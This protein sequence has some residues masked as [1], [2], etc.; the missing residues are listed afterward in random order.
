MKLKSISIILGITSICSYQNLVNAQTFKKASKGLE[1]VIIKDVPG[2]KLIKD[3]S[4]VALHIQTKMADSV[5]FD[6][7]KINNNEPIEQQLTQEFLGGF[8][9]GFTKLSEGDSAILRM[10]VDSAFPGNQK[11]PFAK[12]GDLVSYFIKVV[13]VKTKEEYENGKKEEASI[14]KAV[15]DKALLAYIKQNKLKALKTNSGLYYVIDKAGN[16]THPVATDKVKVHYKGT[17]LD[18]T[19]F[20]SSFDRNEP[21]EFALNGVIK[22]WTEGIPYF[23]EGGKGKLLI[24]SAL[25]Y[26]TNPPPGSSIK[27]N[28]P[29]IFDV[30]LLEIVKELSEA[31][32]M[33]KDQKLIEE[34]IKKNNLKTEKTASGLHFVMEKKGNGKHAKASDEVKVHYKGTLLDGT[35]F[36]S[37]Y[38]RGEPITFPL[39]N[40][41][42][43]WTEGIP[44]L[45]EGGKG[46]LIIPSSLA[47]GKNAPP[48]TPIKANDVLVFDVELL[49]VIAK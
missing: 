28:S 1:Y 22:G 5:M 31:D 39:G 4:Y 15:D 19:K 18:G 24:P 43:G 23:E 29:L 7:Y 37:S 30:E 11:P 14:Q 8:M 38:D 26:G 3:G 6:S 12:P 33:A 32:I 40:V 9:E 10:P 46:K 34:F 36:D 35:K 16:G 25:A 27:A 44:L 13:S 20:D 49:E 48:G 21:I 41:I 17:L 45:E 42:K 2:A 47:Y